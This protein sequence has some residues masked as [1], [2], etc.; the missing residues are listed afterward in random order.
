MHCTGYKT[1]LLSLRDDFSNNGTQLR[2]G[3]GC[4][5]YFDILHHYFVS[6]CFL[7]FPA[8]L[9]AFSSLQAV[10]EALVH[11]GWPQALCGLGTAGLQSLLACCM[12][13]HYYVNACF[14]AFSSRGYSG[15]PFPSPCTHPV[16][17]RR[18]YEVYAIC[19]HAIILS[20]TVRVQRYAYVFNP[21]S[22]W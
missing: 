1:C 21:W 14:G 8:V 16:N 17:P 18:A 13:H 2:P 7:I 22:V 10:L 3:L 19:M 11:C 5:L 15:A 12:L 6:T 9:G 20:M 4:S